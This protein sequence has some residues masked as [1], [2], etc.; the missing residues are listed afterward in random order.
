MT[1]NYTYSKSL[2]TR[3]YDPAFTLVATGSSQSAAG[4]PFDYRKPSLNYGAADFDNTHVV[5]G[6]YV[7]DMPFGRGRKF[8]SQ[9]N[10]GLDWLA[11]GWQ[12]SGDGYWQ[13]GRPLTIFAGSN[14][15]GSSV[16]SPAS[17]DHC[18]AHMGHVHTEIVGGVQ[19]TFF[20]TPEQ[21]AKFYIP[22]AGQFGNTG[23]NW[24]R[25]NAT[26]S[27]DANLS[28]SF[29]TWKEQYLQLRFE[30]QNV[31]NTR[32]YDTMGS[33]L[34]TSTVFARLNAATDGVTNSSPRRAQLAAK[35]VF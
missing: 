26:W 6:Y 3:S 28:K 29:R 16:Q 5:N 23:R 21:R 27:M 11:G 8:G 33:Q 30:V 22:A 10:R 19:Q 20:L 9:W 12:V 13:S 32:S 25:Q 35:Y 31:M 18:D 34:I 14:T 7:L 15:Y 4:T 17:C 2:D 1:V 24:L